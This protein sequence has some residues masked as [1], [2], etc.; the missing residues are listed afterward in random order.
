MTTIALTTLGCKVN[1]FESAGIAEALRRA[2]HTLVPFKERADLYIINTCTVTS[3]TDY[4]S[5]QLIRRARRLN[6]EAAIVVTGCYAQTE[7]DLLAEIEGVTLVVGT[8]MKERIPA[9]IAENRHHSG[10]ILVTDLD[11]NRPFSSLPLSELPGQTRA[12]LKIQ[13]GCNSFCHFCII[14]HTRGRSRSRPAAE[15]IES[16]RDFVRSGYREVVL[17]GIHLGHYGLD[18]ESGPD[19]PSIIRRIEDETSLERLRVSSLEPMDIPD[20]LLTVIGTSRRLCRHFHLAL[21]SGNDWILKQMGRNYSTADFRTMVV[22]ILDQSPGA[23]IGIDVM[24]GYPG[25]TEKE[26]EDTLSFVES[27][28]LAYLHVFPYSRRPG[29]KAFDLGGQVREDVKHHRARLLRE[30]GSEKTLN[31]RQQFIGREVSVLVENKRDRA[32][33][34][35]RGFSDTYIPVCVINGED[36][37]INRIIPV[38]LESLKGALLAGKVL[39]HG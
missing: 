31:Y 34:L 25:E 19:L 26:F 30:L 22:N 12:Y 10:D 13:D 35:L 32:T 7:P 9:L 11:G 1:R 14:P 18:L 27:L 15:V 2:G 23:A 4:Q 17:T 38:T 37:M 39:N 28:P 36:S 21:Q 8:E 20:D 5:R 3:R 24:V 6:P 33:G 16:V 29:T